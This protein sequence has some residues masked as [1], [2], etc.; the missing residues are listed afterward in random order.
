MVEKKKSFSELLSEAPLAPKEDT[1]TLVGA[2]SR[3]SQAGKFVLSTSQGNNI[4]LPVDAVKNYEVLGGGVGQL[5][6]QVDVDRKHVPESIS[7]QPPA[8]TAHTGI[9]DVKQPIHDVKHPIID[10]LPILDKHPIQDVKHPILDKYPWEEP[11]PVTPPPGWP[12][13]TGGGAPFAL[14]TQQQAPASSLAAMQSAATPLGLPITGVRDLK[15]PVT[16]KRPW[17]DAT[18]RPP[19]LD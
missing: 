1:V 4:S 7:S 10:K 15:H 12:V 8:A 16:D 19:F 9:F 3:S 2:I 18:G 11:I 17:L 5:L 14:A 13:E 6:V